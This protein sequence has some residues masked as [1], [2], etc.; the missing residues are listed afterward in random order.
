VGWRSRDQH[1]EINLSPSINYRRKTEHPLSLR[2]AYRDVGGRAKQ[3]ARA[4]RARACPRGG[5]GRG[6]IKQT[7][8]EWSQ[9]TFSAYI[10]NKCALTPFN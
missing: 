7:V 6:G 8:D 9:S 1:F 5:G 3:D 4:E 10:R 2:D